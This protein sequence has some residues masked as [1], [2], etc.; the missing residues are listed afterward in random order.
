MFTF[1]L[2]DADGLVDVVSARKALLFVDYN[3][4]REEFLVPAEINLMP[5][6]EIRY[7]L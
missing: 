1:D 5:Q 4:S 6:D 7:E 3:G 2:R